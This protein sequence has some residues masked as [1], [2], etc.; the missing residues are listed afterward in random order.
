[1]EVSTIRVKGRNTHPQ[2][3]PECGQRE[4]LSLK[5]IIMAKFSRHFVFF[6]GWGVASIEQQL[7]PV[8]KNYVS[9]IS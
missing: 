2:L 9:E 1:M 4:T 6:T 5:Y 8:H 7:P 3:S